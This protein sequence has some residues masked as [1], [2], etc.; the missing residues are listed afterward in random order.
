MFEIV[1]VK[2]VPRQMPV[3]P[4]SL[5]ER[6]AARNDP[7]LTS[8]SIR[9]SV[10]PP[11]YWRKAESATLFC[12]KVAPPRA[13]QRSEEHTSELQSLMRISYAVF[14]LIKTTPNQNTTNHTI[15]TSNRN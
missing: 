5:A 9:S 8:G 4:D 10:T 2:S 15:Q 3:D 6:S 1:S 14:C 13:R 7:T 11:T 12:S